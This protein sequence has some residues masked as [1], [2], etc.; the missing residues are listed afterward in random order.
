MVVVY[1]TDVNDN[2][3][4]V[5]PREVTLTK[6]K[7]LPGERLIT[8]QVSMSPWQPRGQSPWSDL[9]QRQTVTR[10]MTH[11]YT[12]QYV[13]MTT[14]QRSIHTRWPWPRTNGYQGNDLLLYRSVCHHDNPE[15]NPREVTLTKDKRLPGERLITI[16]VSMSPWQQL[17]GQS[18][19]G[20]L[21]QRQTVTRG[22]TH[23]HTGQYVTMTTTQRSIHTRWPWPKTNGYQGNDSSLYRSV[24]HHDNNPEVNPHEVTLTKD[25]RLPGERLITIQ[26]SMSPWQQLR[27]QSSWGDLDQGQTVTRGTTNHYTGQYVTMTT[28]QRSIPVKWPWPRTNGYQGNDSSLY[29]SVCHHDNPE[30]NPCEMTLTKDKRLP[31][32]RL[33][34]IQVSLSYV[35][36]MHLMCLFV[37][38]VHSK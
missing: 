3:P 34:T 17:R 37:L 7:R 5:N 13:T 26:V 32:E 23:H 27:G 22:T 18:T 19:R 29:R 6:D 2:N 11:H 36:R 25:K 8:I 15:V 38:S 24:C 21:D 20:D 28:T 4:E 33:I 9:D 16:Q 1:V 10:G 14:T 31:G 30:V 12:G 35:T